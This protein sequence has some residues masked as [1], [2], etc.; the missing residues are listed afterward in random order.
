MLSIYGSICYQFMVLQTEIH[1]STATPSI[2]TKIHQ[3]I[4]VTFL[5]P[6]FDETLNQIFNS[7]LPKQI[8][9]KK[10]ES[11]R[12]NVL[13]YQMFSIIFSKCFCP[14]KH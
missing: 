11:F 7:L 10:I 13:D 8:I 5:A 3:L 12:K 14:F 4:V 9:I 6:Y 2:G 1:G